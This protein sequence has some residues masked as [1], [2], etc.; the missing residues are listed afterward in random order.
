MF[1]EENQ[2]EEA[3]PDAEASN[4]KKESLD[5]L[6]KIK[7]KLEYMIL[8]LS[9]IYPVHLPI[10]TETYLRKDF[11]FAMYLAYCYGQVLVKFFKWSLFSVSIL[12][13]III[14]VNLLFAI[15]DEEM[16]D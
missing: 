5:K 15:M 14:L 4:R 7:P 10:M 9:F 6:N 8:R 3:N 16:I 2:N 1:Y 11:H 12:A 13:G